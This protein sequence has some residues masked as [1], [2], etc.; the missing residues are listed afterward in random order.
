MT[1]LEPDVT[2]TDYA[3]TLECAVLAWL[4][5]RNRFE[6]R[7]W[8]ASFFA[9]LALAALFGGS[10]H[11]F[12]ADKTSGVHTFV[13]SASLLTIGWAAL[14]IWA[15]G[16]QLILRVS[17]ARVLRRIAAAVY[18]AYVLVVIVVDH[19]FVVA[20]VHYLPAALFL[21][22]SFVVAWHRARA[23]ALL[24]GALG[25]VLT[26]VAAGVQQAGVGLHPRYFNHNAL[27]HLI[28]AIALILLYL[29]MRS[30]KTGRR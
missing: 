15:I 30:I 4:A 29:G 21:L 25:V 28:Q 7:F 22:V 27:Y 18:V 12:F 11:G 10:A 13:W 5:W 9:A 8:C 24:Y 19:R 17:W 2:L 20:I 6:P 26:F 23:P 14:A 3:L 1:L 16:A